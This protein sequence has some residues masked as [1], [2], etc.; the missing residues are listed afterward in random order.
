MTQELPIT[1]RRVANWL[2]HPRRV[3]LQ[4]LI[5]GWSYV[6]LPTANYRNGAV[7]EYFSELN[8]GKPETFIFDGKDGRYLEQIK[9]IYDINNFKDKDILDLGCGNGSF[10]NWLLM[11]NINPK[12]YIGV[13]FAHPEKMLNN[14]A[15]ITQ[16]DIASID[17]DEFS[18][19]TITVVNVLVYLN[20]NI[21]NSILKARKQDAE[22]IIIDPIP[23]L[24]WDAYWG[25]V[26]LFYRKPSRIMEMLKSA[27]WQIKGLS[28]DYGIKWMNYFIFPLSYCLNAKYSR[29]NNS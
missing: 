12:S 19:S 15:R 29:D 2:G 16:K 21:V 27:G 14:N 4:L 7:Y 3:I 25:G 10:F 26:R 13:D 17:L 24:F 22:L 9:M 6:T 8:N 20:T 28:I 11:Q 5:S 23:G 1:R 18:A